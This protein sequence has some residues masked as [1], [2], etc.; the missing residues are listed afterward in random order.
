[1]KYVWLFLFALP[2]AGFINVNPPAANDAATISPLSNFS[3]EWN[4]PKYRACN[5]AA[6]TNY[7]TAEEKKLIYIINLMR[8]NP[9][10]FANTVTKKYPDSC[11]L[12]YLKNTDNFISLLST[13]R[14]LK[15]L[16]LL[17]PDSLCFE[18]A[19]CHAVN[20]GKK[21]YVGH[22]RDN[23][24]SKKKWYYNGECCDYG[25]D[26]ALDILMCLMIDEGVPSLG[27]CSICIS[28]YSKIGVAIR[29]H[30]AYGSNTVLD[31]YY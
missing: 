4:Q 11:G 28:S 30:I 26:K 19:S 15:P 13:L 14:N 16:N 12:G 31:F 23:A 25:H 24:N 20:S 6:N 7:M 1:M 27:H 18:G 8:M 21:G 22:E 9:V 17:Y 5:T 3:A 10:L 2:V 29:P